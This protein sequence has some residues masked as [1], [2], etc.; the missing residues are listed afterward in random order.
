MLL[1]V[2]PSLSPEEDLR[3]IE[4]LSILLVCIPNDLLFCIAGTLPLMF[5]GNMTSQALR[6]AEHLCTV[7]AGD[8]QA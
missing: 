2:E 6:L 1:G 4:H 3:L 5:F 7:W 8:F